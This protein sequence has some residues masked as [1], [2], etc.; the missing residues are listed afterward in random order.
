MDE[1]DFR[2]FSETA[3]ITKI[4]NNGNAKGFPVMRCQM[5]EGKEFKP[6]AYTVF[7]P[8][9]IATRNSYKD[10]ALESRCI[11]LDMS[12]ERSRTDVPLSLPNTF[13]DD[14]TSLRNKLLT[15]RFHNF[16]KKRKIEQVANSVLSERLNQIYTPLLSLIEDKALHKEIVAFAHSQ[17]EQSKMDRG[18]RTEAEV[19]TVIKLIGEDSSAI[20][21]SE[22]TELFQLKYGKNY[23]RKIT[24]KW[25]GGIVR[26]GLHLTTQ[27]QNGN[28]IVAQGQN[29]LLQK[30][31]EKFDVN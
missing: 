8:K 17:A 26:S 16:H 1:A 22:I 15:W 30:L 2:F 3:E 25:I 28:Y 29:W 31:F 6:K 7:S 10:D 5:T 21:I 9:I 13:D 4:L 11:T 27:K 23:D 18:M 24:P 20:R 14:A 12:F 19:L